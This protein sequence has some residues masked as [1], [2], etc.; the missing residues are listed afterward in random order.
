MRN[1]FAAFYLYGLL[2]GAVFASAL[3]EAVTSALK[4]EH[5]PLSSVAVVVQEVN[6]D[7]PLISL[8]A[9]RPMN[10]ASTMKLLTTFAAL[11][12][13]GPAYRWKTEAYLN[14]KLEDGVLQGDL[15]F[16]G[17]GDPKLTVEQ[18]WMWLREL[19]QRGLREIRGDVILDHSFFEKV[20]QDPAEFDNDPSRAYNVGTNAL[21]L[22]FNVLHLQLI[23]NGHETI[24]LLEPSLD[25]YTLVN[26]VTTSNRLRC[27]GKDVYNI[28]LVGHDILL[29]G[30]IPAACGE[31]D[32]YLSLLPQDE[33][34][35]AVFSSLWK[36]LGGTLQGKLRTGTVP[37]DQAPFAKYISPPLSEVIRDIN[38]FSNNIM[39][40][41][42]FLTFGAASPAMNPANSTLAGAGRQHPDD[43]GKH[44]VPP[45]PQEFGVSGS[46]ILAEQIG[47]DTAENESTVDQPL[48][49]SPEVQGSAGGN[50]PAQPESA[51]TQD[52]GVS[53]SG[54]LN[55]T[56]AIIPPA[57]IAH[58]TA[59]MQQWLKVQQLQFPELVLENGAGLS[60]K[61]RISAVHLAEVLQRATS[62]P[63]F[64]ELESSL[65]ILGLDGTVRKRFNE[66]DIAGY[67]HLKTGS[68]EGVKSIAGYV[69]AHSG[70]QW[71]V[72]FLVNHPNAAKA[73]HA[74]DAL[75]DWLQTEN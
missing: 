41:Q 72:V 37:S 13:L 12:T 27:G 74:Q 31:T 21:L 54:P 58:S 7:A 69:K 34:F 44:D 11:E 6:A 42:L 2:T 17:Y 40:R 59:A 48:T 56:K 23:P 28:R 68:L 19:R 3:P 26:R 64:A 8:N 25:G 71:I 20:S 57:N 18:F 9:D 60:R 52:P 62:S 29:E 32:D 22:N 5:I 15:V 66:S 24:A 53:I 70:K 39:A 16:K 65:P 38:K 51:G 14:G 10:P 33:Y 35:F 49:G 1:I 46:T 47:G 50:D 63:F 55:D 61:A 73:Q 45:N 75:I 67:A 30:K 4:H 43:E 36:E